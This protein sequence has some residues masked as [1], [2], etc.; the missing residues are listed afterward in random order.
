MR[1]APLMIGLVAAVSV[2]S[3]LADDNVAQ[4]KALFQSQCGAC[5]TAVPGQQGFGPSLAGVGGRKAGSLAGFHFTDAMS[6]SGLTWDPATLDEFLQGSTK[7]VPGTAM[8]F[9]VS[10]AAD[11]AAIIAYLGTI[12]GAPGASAQAP[13]APVVPHGGPT[14]EEL[15]GAGANARDWLYATKSFEGT[16][17]ADLKQIDTHNAKQLRPVCIYRSDNA[18]PT[19][20]NPIV[21]QGVMYIGV[22]NSVVALDAATCRQ[23]WMY[24]WHPKGPSISLANR[25]VAIK[26]G[27]VVRGTSD[28][29]LIALDMDQGRLIWSR[30]IAE[31]QAGQ[32]LSMPPLMYEDMVI[33]GPAGGDF[34]PKGWVGAFR[35]AT[36]EPMWRFD[37]VPDP[38]A[39]GSETWPDAKAV[40][41]GGGALWTPMSLDAKAGVLYLPVGN[42]APDFYGPLRDGANLYTNS[43]V[44][45]DVH[46]GKLKWYKQFV[47]HDVHDTDLSQVSPLFSARIGGRARNLITVSGKDG[48]LR[49]MDRD[50][51]EVLSELPVTTRTNVDAAP[52]VEGIHR[53][54]GLLGGVEWNGPA[55]NP[56]T[57]TLF[58]GAND[59]CGTFKLSAQAPAFAPAS[60]YYGG[61]VVPDAHDQAHGWITAIDAVNGKVRWKK[62]WPT[63]FSAG[64]VA[65]SGGVLFTGGLD[66]DFVALDAADGKELYRFNTGGSIG[67]GV[68]TYEV[69]GKQYVATTSGVISGFHGGS[70]TSAV[71]VLA[72]P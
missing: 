56:R 70:G 60:H 40:Q 53:C 7:K 52:S 72:L 33:Y 31:Q 32:Y 48:L 67:G 43:V 37:L 22:E 12:Q 34:G 16:R 24:V 41:H 2:R 10:N 19:Q 61:E 46:T 36:G 58:V 69:K 55:Y 18:S 42:P 17:F 44:A 21:Y 1:I 9:T 35:I 28:G 20:T 38:D 51:Q 68:V 25:G 11:R 47:P 13:A 59:W 15:V 50:T 45:L 65:T 14:Q 54:P 29:W 3:A 27:V 4:G 63:P 23:K 39:P 64:I 49:V 57:S 26:D 30:K 66:N 5:H 71:V 62:A 6:N 8:D